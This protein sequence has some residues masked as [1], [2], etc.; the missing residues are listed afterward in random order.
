MTAFTE[1]VEAQ[2]KQVAETEQCLG[3]E[4]NR[5]ANTEAMLQEVRPEGYSWRSGYFGEGLTFENL[6]NQELIIC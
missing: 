6:E 2:A 4:R 5:L 1:T 3:D